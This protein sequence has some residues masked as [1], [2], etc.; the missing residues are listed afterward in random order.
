M[1]KL[2]TA[3][4]R[5]PKLSG[6]AAILAGAVIVPAALLAWGPDRPTFTIEKPASYVTFNSITNNPKHG[7]ERNF[8]QIRNYT[9][10]TQ[11]GEN[12]QLVPGKEY[13]VYVYYHNNASTDLNSAANNYKGIALNSYMKVQMPATVDAGQKAR[14]TGTVGASNAK[15]THVWDE[16]YGTNASN[17]TV[18]LRY[19]PNSAKI[20]NT[21]ASNGQVIDLNK[22]ASANGALLGYDKLDGKLPGCMKY[23]GYVTYRFKVD[24][25]NFEV[26]K[27]VSE[28][29]KNSWTESLN[30][31]AGDLV[32]FRIHYK[33]TGTVV[34]ENVSIRDDLPK[35]MTL[36]EGSARYFSSKTNGAWKVIE[37]KD[38]ITT[39]G[40]DFGSFGANGG[41]YVALQ[42][43]VGDADTLECGKNTL[44]N[45]A[46]VTTP[47]GTK[48]DSATVIVEKECEE[49]KPEMVKV[50]DL[51]DK[52][53]KE[54]SK[55]TYE[56]DKDRYTTDLSKCDQP[57]KEDEV[58]VCNPETGKLITVKESD[59]DKYVDKDSK[60]CKD[61]PVVENVV[62]ELPQTGLAE[63][64]GS[65]LGLG[66]LT[67][68]AYYYVT[69]R[70]Q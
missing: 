70:R 34:Q 23:T 58:V 2:L 63:Q 42:A 53:V 25:P 24:Q 8:V 19:V 54:I 22:L 18:A 6:L 14:V 31:N 61:A 36:V 40:V 12:T 10:N 3:I 46:V 13:E 20:T 33:N 5:A 60:E 44:V 59:A 16:A 55:E 69:S 45:R 26:K 66:A 35:G 43:R 57:V 17:G 64:L 32:D 68:A 62:T 52:T 37:D 47:N 21:G 48:N 4:R 1:K 7:D 56:A 27:E 30:A 49:P 39:S 9:D 28:K 15:P 50:C 29:G 38:A 65:M 51:D 67:T 41:M 11:F